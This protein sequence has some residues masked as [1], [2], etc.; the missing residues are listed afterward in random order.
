MIQYESA[1]V[2]KPTNSSNLKRAEKHQKLKIENRIVANKCENY[3]VK[4]LRS[5]WPNNKLKNS[6]PLE[7]EEKEHPKLSKNTSPHASTNNTVSEKEP[8][9]YKYKADVIFLR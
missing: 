4:N 8:L 2:Q 1:F 3:E 9:S 7:C 6:K 5:Q